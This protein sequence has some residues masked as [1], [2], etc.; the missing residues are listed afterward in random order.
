M[1]SLIRNNTLPGAFERYEMYSLLNYLKSYKSS[2]GSQIIWNCQL[3]QFT[4]PKQHIAGLIMSL[5]LCEMVFS[6]YTNFLWNPQDQI[7]CQVVLNSLSKC[8]SKMDQDVSISAVV[9]NPTLR[10]SLFKPSGFFNLEVVYSLFL[11]LW[12]MSLILNYF[13]ASAKLARR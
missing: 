12:H 13:C 7:V 9:L 6:R 1:I 10:V 11:H 4:L 5:W 8:W 3:F 2:L